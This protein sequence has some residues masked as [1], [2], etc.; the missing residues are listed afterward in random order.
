MGVSDEQPLTQREFDLFQQLARER[1]EAN[2][3]EQG[4]LGAEIDLVAGKALADVQAVR[5]EHATDMAKLAT[6]REQDLKDAREQR[7]EDLDEAKRAAEHRK[8]WSWTTKFTAA[9]LGL[10]IVGLYV[11]YILAHK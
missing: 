4:R 8:E 6:Q 9:G 2:I 10:A 5:Q 3:R 1:Q 11:Q 7:D